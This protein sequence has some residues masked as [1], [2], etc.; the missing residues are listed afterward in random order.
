MG[1]LYGKTLKM[2]IV[3]GVFVKCISEKIALDKTGR[4]KTAALTG[5][6]RQLRLSGSDL[7]GSE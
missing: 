3:T 7:P 2:P 1:K 5:R 4:T 6:F